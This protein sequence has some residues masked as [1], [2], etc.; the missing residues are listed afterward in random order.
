MLSS[1]LSKNSCSSAVIGRFVFILS[2]LQNCWNQ[3]INQ[4]SNHAMKQQKIL[5]QR[6]KTILCELSSRVALLS[7]PEDTHPA[8]PAP[9][10]RCRLFLDKIKHHDVMLGL[11]HCWCGYL[12]INPSGTCD[13]TDSSVHRQCSDAKIDA[14]KKKKHWSLQIT[15]SATW[16]N[17]RPEL[18]VPVL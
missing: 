1:M 6:S 5:K 2:L 4:S 18:P 7:I 17:R 16:S 11:K 12:H 10:V 15:P 14:K 8:H 9:S 13:F 3:A